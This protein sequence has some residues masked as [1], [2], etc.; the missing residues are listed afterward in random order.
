MITISKLL[1]ICGDDYRNAPIR[2]Q[3]ANHSSK[4]ATRVS[5]HTNQDGSRVVVIHEAEIAVPQPPE[6]RQP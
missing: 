5:L 6:L 2:I 3:E 4:A 1:E